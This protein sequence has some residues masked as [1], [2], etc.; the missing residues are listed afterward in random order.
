MEAL[1]IHFLIQYW[2]SCLSC[3]SSFSGSL[4]TD[5]YKIRGCLLFTQVLPNKMR[6]SAKKQW[7]SRWPPR[8]TWPLWLFCVMAWFLIHSRTRISL[9][10]MKEFDTNSSFRAG[11][12]KVTSRLLVLKSFF[13]IL[14]S[15]PLPMSQRNL[16]FHGSHLP[17]EYTNWILKK[18]GKKSRRNDTC[19]LG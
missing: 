6:S 10:W 7:D 17:L 5:S 2:I 4:V 3:V 1:I 18:F 12:K 13:L 15:S 19:E 14:R 11:G 16:L 8:P 9:I